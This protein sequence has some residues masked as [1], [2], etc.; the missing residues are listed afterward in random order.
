MAGRQDVVNRKLRETS[1]ERLAFAN[2]R[3]RVPLS[4][5]TN[6]SLDPGLAAA[7]TSGRGTRLSAY[8]ERLIPLCGAIG[9]LFVSWARPTNLDVSWLLTVNERILAGVSPY[10]G[11]IELNPPASIL[12]YR[13][14]ALVAKLLS[15]RAELVVA[16]MLALLVASVLGYAARIL[17]RYE[18]SESAG[19][20]VFLAASAFVLSVLPFDEIAQRE[21]FA[22]IF[23]FPY[24][25][26]AIARAAGKQ[27]APRDGLVAGTMLGL[28]IAIKPHFALC[29]LMVGGFEAVRSRDIRALFRIEHWAA[30]AVAVAYFAASMIFYPKF[31]SDILPE[32]A[33]LYLPLRIDLVEL[34]KRAA[35]PILLPAAIC[36]IFRSPRLNT[37][38][39]V[40][41]LIAAGFLCAYLIQGKGWNY[42]A[43]PFVAFSLIAASWA[44]QQWRSEAAGGAR[45][46]GLLVLAIA[47]LLPA[48]LFF[49]AD[50]SHP[51]LTAAITRLAP[52]PR[53]L[54]IAFPQNLGHPLT[55]DIGG[56]WVGR[57]WGLWATEGAVLMKKRVGDDPAL[58]AKA[59]AYFE[60]DRLMLTQDIENQHPDIVLLQE[61]IG[62]DFAR[63]IA[64]SPRLQAAM[65]DY[66][67]VETIDGVEIFQRRGDALG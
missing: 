8:A 46:L 30:G 53:I 10:Q 29:A 16:G 47:L 40:L 48:R 32:I 52:H 15:I 64:E 11:V 41:L 22:T 37:G 24:A 49:R 50:V 56:I 5:T 4:A 6:Q 3:R 26:I 12:L 20:G 45:K 63:W 43:Y 21:H 54:T 60:N 66:R 14:P 27:I 31:F 1:G 23:I 36:W 34:M 38:T 57:S 19:N 39:I 35:L 51:G 18:L 58:R 9:V 59:D 62:F 67:L 61:T 33:D 55:R 28:C 25:L 65:T 13:I 44:M 2:R 7:N 42:H 17:S